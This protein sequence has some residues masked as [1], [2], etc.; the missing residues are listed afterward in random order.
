MTIFS[1]YVKRVYAKPWM[2]LLTVA[3]PALIVIIANISAGPSGLRVALFDQ[4]DSVLSRAVVQAIE[5]V[6]VF[7]EVDLSTIQRALFEARIDY[8]LILPKGLQEQV[9]RGEQAVVQSYSL[10]G[11]DSTGVIEASADSVFSAAHA[12]A[13]AANGSSREFE[14]SLTRMIEGRTIITVVP[15]LPERQTLST[16]AASGLAQLVALVTVAMFI[17]SFFLSQYF[18]E[19]RKAGVIHRTLT[20][21]ISLVRYMFETNAAFLLVTGLQATATAATV[22]IILYRELTPATG[23]LLGLTLLLCALVAVSF[24][25]GIVALSKTIRRSQLLY[26]LILLPMVFLGGAF[27]P[28]EIMPPLFQRFSAFTPIRWTVDATEQILQGAGIGEILPHLAVLFL[29]GVVFQ[30]LSSWRPVDIA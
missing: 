5:P 19:D 24:A 29:F 26:N 13:A 28:V 12:I 4:D 15:G 16:A 17:S 6:S 14:Q 22:S 7:V 27:W 9:L 20:G 23:F 25:L 3:V 21:P 8:A 18:L 11:I 30:L 10:L 1:T 2:I